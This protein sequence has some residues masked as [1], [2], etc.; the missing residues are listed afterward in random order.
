MQFGYPFYVAAA[1][2][3]GAKRR[4]CG[5]VRRLGAVVVNG[6]AEDPWRRKFVAVSETSQSGDAFDVVVV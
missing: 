1:E 3:V 4:R 2:A 5:I 6:G